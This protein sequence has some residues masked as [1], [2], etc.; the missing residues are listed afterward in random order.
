MKKVKFL[1]IIVGRPFPVRECTKVME[2]NDF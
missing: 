1:E 2:K